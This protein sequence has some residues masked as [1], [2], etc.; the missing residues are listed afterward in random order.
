MNMISGMNIHLFITGSTG[1]RR[2]NAKQGRKYARLDLSLKA[3]YSG[4][5]LSSFKLSRSC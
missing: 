1:N 2:K 3:S 4:S 5:A